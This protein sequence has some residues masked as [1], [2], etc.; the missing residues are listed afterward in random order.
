MEDDGMDYLIRDV[1]V[2]TMNGGMEVIP[3]GAV[4]IAGGTVAAVAEGA[5]LAGEEKNPAVRVIDGRGAIAL[6]GLINAHTHAGMIPFRSLG[7]DCADRLRRFLL[8]LEKRAMTGELAA[9]SARYACAEMLLAGVTCFVDMYY[10]EDAVAAAVKSAGMRAFLGETVME[11]AVCDS[12]EAHGGLVRGERFIRQWRGDALVT[13]MIAPHATNTNRPDKI[14]EAAALARRYD[15]PLTMHVSEMDYEMEYFRTVHG[16]TPVAFLNALG[17]LSPRFI[18]AHC[19][20]VDAEDI[21]I[22]A[23]T[24]A[25]VAHCIGANTKSGKGVA[26]V[27]EMLEAGVRVALGTDGPASGNTLDMFTQF[28]LFAKFHKTAHRDRTLFPASAIVALATSGAAAALGIGDRVGSIEPGKRAD[29]ILVE[30]E[31][32]NMFPCF[33]PYSVLVYSAKAANVDTVFVNGELLVR[34]KKL[35]GRPLADI[36]RDLDGAMGVFRGEA[37]ALSHDAA[38]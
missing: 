17:V 35:T 12:G 4:L 30:T 14:R 20:H 22:L 10:F 24:G 15:V 29:I 5:A 21:R 16:M 9:L 1:C 13:P 38:R 25:A 37:A 32:A 7:D 28:D 26:P 8:P 18:A 19:I 6:P 3:A 2:V 11:E 27:K 33:D 31:S 23:A 34:E 36:R